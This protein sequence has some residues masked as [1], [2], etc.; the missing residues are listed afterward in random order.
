MPTVVE[1]RIGPKAYL[2][3]VNLLLAA[4]A[5]GH[6]SRPAVNASQIIFRPMV[7]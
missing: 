1:A 4:P 5:V 7:F 3:L 2:D 6:D